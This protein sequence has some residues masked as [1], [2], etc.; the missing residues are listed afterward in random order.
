MPAPPPALMI[1]GVCSNAGKSL[2]AAAI[3]RLLVRRGA[4]VAPFKAQNMALNSFVTDNGEEMG[5][6]QALQAVACGLSPDVRMNPVLLKPTS[7]TGSQI[8]VMGRPVGQMNVREYL[9]YKAK[10][11]KAVR[12]AYNSLAAGR[13]V[14]VLEGAGS[15]AEINLKAHDIVNM[16]MA[17]HA[18]ANVLLVA[19]ID[20]GGAFA[21]L[22]GTMALLGR[23]DRARVAGYVLNKF[24]GDAS[25]LDPAIGAIHRRTGRPFVGVVPM[26]ENLCLPEEDSVN[27]KLGDTPML[28]RGAAK[29]DGNLLDIVIVD[30]PHISNCTDSDALR[31]EPGVSVRAV[32]RAED[33]G[34]PHAVIL[35]GSKNVI[36][37]LRFLYETGLAGGIIRLA[38]DGGARGRGMVV[39]VCGGLQMLG[40]GITDPLFLES[41]GRT[42]GLGLLPMN[43]RLDAAKQLRRVRGH[44]AHRLADGA[45]CVEGYEI[46]HGLSEPVERCGAGDARPMEPVIYDAAGQ[47]LGWGL[48]EKDGRVRVWG[49]YMHGIFDANDFRHAFLNK[50][51]SDAGLAPQAGVSYN[52][53]AELDRLAD[54]VEKNLDMPT[55]Y[56]LTKV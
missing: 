28:R 31:A 16:R 54:A 6:A 22:T 27:F 48:V 56:A 46:H 11:W 33:L 50:L 19:D 34:H 5:R 52:L 45:P 25:L 43:T 20:R 32:R 37:D 24:R 23:G 47:T 30:L 4:N 44:A 1:Q 13:D 15:P 18:G 3:C 29:A 12:K 55:V 2:L 17:R 38:Q 21:A 36:A 9:R 42:D 10:A 8:I 53:G 14:M 49:T 35:P 51:R 41:G 26:L 7:H 40:Q 39:G